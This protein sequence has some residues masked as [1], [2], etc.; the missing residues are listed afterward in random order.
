VLAKKAAASIS[1]RQGPEHEDPKGVESRLKREGL[2]FKKGKAAS[3]KRSDE[4][5]RD[6]VRVSTAWPNH[7]F[8]RITIQVAS[9]V[10][11]D[12]LRTWCHKSKCSL[13]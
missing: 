10:V 8:H 4:R 13:R 7:N 2:A 1:R 9:E 12:Y 11:L 5:W 6:G 3:V